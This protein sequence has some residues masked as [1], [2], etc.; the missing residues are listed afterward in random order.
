MLNIMI[1]F[2]VRYITNC[3]RLICFITLYEIV[4]IIVIIIINYYAYSILSAD[5]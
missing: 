4:L 2:T 5:N 3:E 1:L